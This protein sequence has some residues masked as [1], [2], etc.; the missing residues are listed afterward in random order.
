M[1]EWQILH[2]YHELFRIRRTAS[3]EQLA[4]GS[5]AG[6]SPAPGT[7][8]QQ[9]KRVLTELKDSV[10]APAAELLARPLLKVIAAHHTQY[11]LLPFPPCFIMHSGR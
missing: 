9:R 2:D 10:P 1:F 4:E 3:R 11:H 7:F 6:G 8:K 5:A